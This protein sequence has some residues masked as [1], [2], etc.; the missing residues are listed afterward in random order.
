MG[1]GSVG[2]RI[3]GRVNAATRSALVGSTIRPDQV[4]SLEQ[5]VEAIVAL[6]ACSP[7]VTGRTFV[8]LDLLADWN[9]QVRGL[10]AQ[11]RPGPEE[12]SW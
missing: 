2:G 12:A 9:V 5:M 3:C 11:A 7:D 1:D 8:S 10:D 4:E 6:C